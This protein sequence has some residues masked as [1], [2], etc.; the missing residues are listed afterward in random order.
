M[1]K[2]TSGQWCGEHHI[3]GVKYNPSPG[4]AWLVKLHHMF[5]FKGINFCIIDKY[6]NLC[7]GNWKYTQ[8]QLDVLIQ[9]SSWQS[10]CTDDM[11]WW[12]SHI[13]VKVQQMATFSCY[14]YICSVY[15]ES[16]LLLHRNRKAT[17]TKALLIYFS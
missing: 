10:V 1:Q 16:L 12:N 15:F 9:L 17:D 3:S 4:Q 6:K 2:A 13:S 7:V 14:I 8:L 11:T 5:L